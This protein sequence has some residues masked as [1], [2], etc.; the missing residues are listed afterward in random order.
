MLAELERKIG[1]GIHLFAH[2]V[3]AAREHLA[4]LL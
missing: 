3:T 1:T 4:K 2:E